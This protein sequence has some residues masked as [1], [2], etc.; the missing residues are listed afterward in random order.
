MS[1]K[2]RL[3]ALSIVFLA[4]C[5]AF[6]AVAGATYYV[7]PWEASG[8][9][10]GAYGWNYVEAYPVQLAY[11]SNHLNSIY[12]QRVDGQAYVEVGWVA[13]RGNPKFRDRWPIYFI[14]WLH[15]GYRYTRYGN[16]VSVPGTDHRFMVHWQNSPNNE[17]H[18]LIDGGLVAIGALPEPY[19][20]RDAQLLADS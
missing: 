17:W 3:L 11:F 2:K 1:F 10:Y 4:T 8:Y 7:V 20:L 6:P 18:F 19:G 5:S 13:W 15:R 16:Y 14:Q 12:A 9:Y